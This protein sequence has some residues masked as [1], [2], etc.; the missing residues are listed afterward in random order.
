MDVEKVAA[1]MNHSVVVHR[2]YK[3]GAT[4]NK[5]A[6]V[7]KFLKH[8]GHRGEDTDDDDD[9]NDDDN[10][11]DDC[12]GDSDG[13][14]YPSMT[15]KRRKDLYETVAKARD[16]KRRQI[17]EA[18]REQSSKSERPLGG[19]TFMPQALRMYSQTSFYL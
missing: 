14:E 3:R 1:S 5:V 19:R 15:G 10:G 12:D 17:I 11:D 6:L 9:D 13:D 8:H 4:R 18:E 16:A 2:D 7:D